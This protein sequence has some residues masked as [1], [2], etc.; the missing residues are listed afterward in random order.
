MTSKRELVRTVEWLESTQAEFKKFHK[1]VETQI[2]AIHQFLR[3]EGY[4]CVNGGWIKM[5]AE[6]QKKYVAIAKRNADAITA[7]IKARLGW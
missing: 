4:T 5:S 7:E 1:K 6:T 2:E 3:T